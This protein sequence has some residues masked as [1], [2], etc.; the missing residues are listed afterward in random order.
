MKIIKLTP[1]LLLILIFS[2]PTRSPAPVTNAVEV[3]EPPPATP[4]QQA[5]NATQSIT[6]PVF[7]M[8]SGFISG[9]V[10]SLINMGQAQKKGLQ[11]KTPVA[12][13]GFTTR[14][15]DD[16]SVGGFGGEEYSGDLGVDA[17]AFGNGRC[18]LT[19]GLSSFI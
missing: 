7:S 3:V 11:F 16:S 13:G 6:S 17:P 15:F 12:T 2:F 1:I 5:A 9:A 10:N 18:V 4:E 14:L 19:R 8:A